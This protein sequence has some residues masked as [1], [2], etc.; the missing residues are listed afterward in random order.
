MRLSS[1]DIAQ[2]RSLVQAHFGP[3]TGIWLFGSRLD[4]QA[5]GGDIDL[6]LEPERLP[7]DNLFLARQ[8]LRGVLERQLRQPV[9]LVVN[10]GQPTAFM[11]QARA[12]GQQL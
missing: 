5:R 2:I 3:S 7:S 11:R 1:D 4:D 6:Y 9:D 12:E 10:P 8:A